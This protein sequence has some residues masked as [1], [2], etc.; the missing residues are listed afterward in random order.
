MEEKYYTPSIS[1]FHVG[2][3]YEYYCLLD[4]PKKEKGWRKQTIENDYSDHRGA[5]I[6][7]PFNDFDEGCVRVKRLDRE[8][9]ESLGWVFHNNGFNDMFIYNKTKYTYPLWNMKINKSGSLTIYH[10]Q[11]NGD[12]VSKAVSDI[13]IKNKSELKRIMQQLGI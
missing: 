2:F 7:I 10:L 12:V 11:E 9:I 8:D 13:F 3:E 5:V 4:W 6:P 1:E